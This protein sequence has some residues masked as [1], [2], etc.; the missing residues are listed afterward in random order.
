MSH[1]FIAD[2]RLFLQSF[3]TLFGAFC[4]SN[5]KAEASDLVFCTKTSFARIGDI[6]DELRIDPPGSVIKTL[7]ALFLLDHKLID[8]SDIFDCRGSLELN[9]KT[10]ICVKPH[11]K[12]NLVQAVADSCNLYFLKAL[13]EVKS[14]A[15][16]SHFRK[17][18]ELPKKSFFEADKKELIL[19]TSPA[20][21]ITPIEMLYL[22]ETLSEICQ[23]PKYLHLREGMR[24]AALVGTA[25]GTDPKYRF[26]LAVKTGSV[27]HGNKFH[28]WMI[29]FA[30]YD[31]PVIA[32]SAYTK[33]GSSSERLLPL[34]RVRLDDYWD[35]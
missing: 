11:G 10:Q 7:D 4:A 15:L 23:K 21:K 34:V 20:L 18:I 33:T 35:E 14:E 32:F 5:F 25:K 17:Y 28:S 9:G 24:L 13:H 16:S 27:P 6:G 29:G 2:R 19:G 31:S 8:P 1:Q 22:A 26:K 3:T 12:V 30:P